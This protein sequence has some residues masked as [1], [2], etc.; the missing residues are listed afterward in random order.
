MIIHFIFVNITHAR[1]TNNSLIA[2][3]GNIMIR[4]RDAPDGTDE[5]MQFAKQFGTT[6]LNMLIKTDENQYTELVDSLLGMD[7]TDDV[8]LRK[9]VLARY[10][11]H[12]SM[13]EN[14]TVDT[15][16]SEEI[17]KVIQERLSKLPPDFS[18]KIMYMNREELLKADDTLGCIYA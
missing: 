10:V 14:K 16:K 13:L 12:G 4:T 17:T 11:L 7:L 8:Q 1:V 3:M 6:N 15:P 2:G 5:I 9:N 18:S